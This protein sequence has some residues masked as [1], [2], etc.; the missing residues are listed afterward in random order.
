MVETSIMRERVEDQSNP[1]TGSHYSFRIGEKK[2]E[3]IRPPNMLHPIIML[4]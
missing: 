1:T 4:G 2:P 3:T